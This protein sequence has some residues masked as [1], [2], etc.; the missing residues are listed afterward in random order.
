MKPCILPWINFGTNTYGKAR[1]C[2]YSSETSDVW[3]F[4]SKYFKDIRNSFL[5]NEWPKNCKRCRHVEELGGT[6]KRMDENHMWYDK[7]KH[8]IGKEVNYYPP[9]LDVRTG[10]ICNFKCIHCGPASSSKWMEDYDLIRSFGYNFPPV[11][12]KWITQENVF[13]DSLDISQI[14]RYNF[15]GGESFYN[16]RHN[17]FIKRLNESE[18]AKDVE[19]A[20]VSNGSLR[21]ENME[22]FK[23]VRLRL[24]VDCIREAGE[25]FRY[26]LNW[27][28]WCNNIRNFPSNF[29]V[30]FQWTCSNVSMFYLK[31]TYTYMRNEFSNIRFLFENHVTEPYHMSAQNLPI[32]IKEKIQKDIEFIEMPD[33]YVNYMKEKDVWN[34]QGKIFLKYLH[35]LDV[36]RNTNWKNNLSE[37]NLALCQ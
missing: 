3:D 10:T 15:L 14:K 37:L 23:K 6:S 32:K 13:W 2:G 34:K 18:Y 21:F 28:D 11:D 33:F 20:Y 27:N 29:D 24:S 1:V 36:K 30:S 16:K 7:F 22:N 26:G 8:L 35:D 25:Y 9:H 31:D 5:K 4:N 17:E 12:D 19:I